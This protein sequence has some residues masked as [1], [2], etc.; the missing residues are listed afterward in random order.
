MA[1][2]RSDTRSND[3]YFLLKGANPMKNFR[4]IFT[5][6]FLSLTLAVQ[7]SAGWESSN[8]QTLSYPYIRALTINSTGIFVGSGGGGIFISKDGGLNWIQSGSTTAKVYSLAANGATVFAGTDAGVSRSFDNGASWSQ[9]NLP[10]TDV[11][12]LAIS[13][14]VVVAGT[15]RNG[16]YVS[17]DNGSNWTS[18]NAGLSNMSVRGL[19]VVG[20]TIFAATAGAGVFR[21]VNNGAT[22][23]ASNSGLSS[24]GQYVYALT[25]NGSTIFAGTQDG[26]YRSADNGF[27]W[28]QVGLSNGSLVLS[29]AVS[30]T[31][32]FAGTLGGGVFLIT[33]NATNWTDI[34]SGLLNK[35]IYALAV[36]GTDLFAGTFGTGVWRR[37]LSDVVSAPSAPT[38]ISPADGATGISTSSVLTWNAPNGAVSF[39]VQVSTSPIF[40]TT[41]VNQSGITAPS[42][43]VSGLANN[44]V[45]YWR[46][47]ATNANGTSPWSIPVSFTTATAAV[48]V[49]ISDTT[50]WKG[51]R[52]DVPVTI[53]DITNRNVLAFQF[54]LTF[55][56]PNNILSAVDV[57]ASGTLSGASG[58][59]LVPN[60][61]SPNKIIVGAFGAQPLS[62]SGI[63]MKIRFNVDSTAVQGQYSDLKFSDFIINSGTPVVT[64]TNGKVRISNV[65]WG[66]ADENGVVQAYDAALTLR[67]AIGL[68]ALSPQGKLNAD[69]DM[70]G[71]VQSY[72]AALILRRVLGLPI[73]NIGTL[74]KSAGAIGISAVD[75]QPR[76]IRL[77]FSGVN[78][79]DGIQA[80]SFDVSLS[81]ND[82]EAASVTC[83]EL[84][85]DYLQ[86]VN[87]VDDRHYRIGIINPKGIDSKD[88]KITIGNCHDLRISNI[89]L[90]NTSVPDVTIFNTA[91]ET[92]PAS[93]NLVGAYPNPFNPATRIVFVNPNSSLVKIEIFDMKGTLVKTVVDVEM[94]PGRHEIMWD[95]T[96]D[97]LAHVASGQYLCRIQS[98]S[99]MRSIKILLLK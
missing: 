34:G 14:S 55:N 61:S 47:N 37:P 86:A 7:A 38:I 52:V 80:I 15:Y 29:F 11:N 33:N 87:R 94:E 85:S 58:W 48:A 2:K 32:L 65:V 96:N 36:N 79:I 3:E 30:G 90:N 28:I 19:L 27:S 42:Y 68:Q 41:L 51:S 70:N 73:L 83:A 81:P 6:C 93:F 97:G 40:L 71:I 63:L 99:F 89:L 69:V 59:T 92:V 82:H 67:D 21:S 84:S 1:A 25:V 88:L 9:T 74:A 78:P 76:S 44:T 46:V 18:M 95:G 49:N 31:N 20:N 8:Y 75:E 60:I 77:A 10:S 35:D 66:D 56:T 43:A 12:S 26:V 91:D 22:W 50:V 39:Q 98:G 5:Y 57:I 72:D 62:G 45:Y 17:A 13:S 23:S 16:I 53:G 64:T 4:L 54:T 24:L